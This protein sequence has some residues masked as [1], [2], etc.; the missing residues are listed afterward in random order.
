MVNFLSGVYHPKDV[1]DEKVS[2]D[3]FGVIDSRKKFDRESSSEIRKMLGGFFLPMPF[4]LS[5]YLGD[6]H[7]V[8]GLLE[9]LLRTYGMVDDVT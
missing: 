6:Q 7:K 4:S 8:E 3:I 9:R 5:F 1:R 2:S